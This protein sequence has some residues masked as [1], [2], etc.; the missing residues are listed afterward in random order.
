MIKRVSLLLVAV[1]SFARGQDSSLQEDALALYAQ[2]RSLAGE[3]ATD[4]GAGLGQSYVL[5]VESERQKTVTEN[6]LMEVFKERGANVRLAGDV[7]TA[8]DSVLS[9]VVLVHGAKRRELS[10][11]VIVN[12]IETV[13]DA[14]VETRSG[15]VP[16]QKTFRRLSTDTLR[17]DTLTE[18]ATLFER[19]LEPAIVIGSA[20]LVVFLL[21]TVRSS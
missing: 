19:L 7:G 5:R 8:G 3:L 13:M 10:D 17:T 2:L 9:V 18:K 1:L 11:G 4:F 21:F 6:L 16:I 14:R 15:E 12:D 20:I